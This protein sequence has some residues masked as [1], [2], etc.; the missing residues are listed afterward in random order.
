MTALGMPLFAEAM[1]VI[2]C[3]TP[4]TE[5]GSQGRA[6][7]TIQTFSHCEQI[8]T[9]MPALQM[10][11][12]RGLQRSLKLSAK[13][14]TLLRDPRSRGATSTCPDWDSLSGVSCSMAC[15]QRVH[16]WVFGL[17]RAQAVVRLELHVS[18][19]AS[20][21]MACRDYGRNGDLAVQRAAQ[22]PKQVSRGSACTVMSTSALTERS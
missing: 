18:G 19:G 10:S 2:P 20:C 22:E 9:M 13:S 16:R 11:R 8:P 7:H 6:Y 12:S 1:E 14:R 17:V 3:P 5:W 4:C 21:C 15:R